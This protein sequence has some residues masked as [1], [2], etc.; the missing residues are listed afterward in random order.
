M[1]SFLENKIPFIHYK[2]P[3]FTYLFFGPLFLNHHKLLRSFTCYKKKKCSTAQHG[4]FMFTHNLCVPQFKGNDL[5]NP[6]I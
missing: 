4:D 6:F 2:T 1:F 3:V 5:Y